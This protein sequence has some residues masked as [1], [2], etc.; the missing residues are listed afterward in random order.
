[1]KKLLCLILSTIFLFT[2][3]SCNISNVT[4]TDFSQQVTIVKM[5]SPP[6]CK[7][8]KKISDVN[9]II[10][11]LGEIKKTPISNE[12]INGGWSIMVKLNIDGQ[13]FNYTI[14]SVFTDS[15]G[16]QYYVQNQDEIE[17]KILDIY[18]NIDAPEVDYP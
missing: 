7:T 4:S 18:E 16:K 12:E 3:C 6:K 11:I 10:N 5:P 2:L 15:D 1:M 14:G 9:K 17:D 8:S 13:D